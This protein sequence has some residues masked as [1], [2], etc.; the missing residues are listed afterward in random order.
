MT[1]HINDGR[2]FLRNSTDRYDLVVFALPDSL[3]LVSTTANVRLESFLFTEEAFGSVRD[4]LAP[5]GVFVL[6]NYYREPWLVAK[7]DT[8]LRD[9]FGHAPLLRLYGGVEA[10]LASGPAVAALA[11]GPPPGDRVDAV[12]AVTGPDPKPATDDWPF[13]YL[14]VPDVAPYYLAALAFV[15]ALAIVLVVGAARATDTPIRRFSPHFFVLGMAFLL[16]ETRSLVS[17]SL[18]FGATWL[19]NALTFFAI[20]ASVLLAIVV[21]A[22]WPIRR[23]GLLYVGLFGALAVA[24]V[25]P[26]ESLLLDPPALR[27]GIAATVAF[28]PVFF[29]NLVFSHSFRETK[30]AD[31]SFASN[32]LG[33]LAGGVLEY[34]ALLGGYR[35][36]LL[37]VAGLYVMAYLLA[38]RVRLLADVDLVSERT[39]PAQPVAATGT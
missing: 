11:G 26:P 7:L 22:R 5:G 2:A 15:L 9:A 18:L 1:V 38:T 3:T 21:N 27:Y 16:L 4:H 10:A 36:L 14:R 6:Y 35:S 32:L 37:V 25:L 19:V 33:A 23:P 8:M 30:T 39:G 28:A 34:L 17:F 12:P 31:M 24:S 13:L 29:A 20:L